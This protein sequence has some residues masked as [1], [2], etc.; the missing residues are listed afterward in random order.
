ML[1]SP[2]QGD[3]YLKTLLSINTDFQ[4]Y[5]LLI[6]QTRAAAM[7]VI[8]L[9]FIPL[10]WSIC[11]EHY[12]IFTSNLRISL[13]QDTVTCLHTHVGT[14]GPNMGLLDLNY[15]NFLPAHSTC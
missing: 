13:M 14:T 11:T 8:Y 9:V 1:L 7:V 10:Y 5:K 6:T 15:W 12:Y 3:E 4:L 2:Q